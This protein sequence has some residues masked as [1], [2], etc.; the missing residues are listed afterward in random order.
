MSGE[1]LRASRGS[2]VSGISCVRSKGSW[3]VR[4]E[5]LVAHILR[6]FLIL[7]RLRSRHEDKRNRA[8]WTVFPGRRAP[9]EILTRS[10]DELLQLMRL[11]SW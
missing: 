11:R 10:I 8:L 1:I 9:S 4:I 3:N 5:V 7:P 6:S 2:L